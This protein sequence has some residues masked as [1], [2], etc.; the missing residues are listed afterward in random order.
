ML[1]EYEFKIRFS[2]GATQSVFAQPGFGQAEKINS[3]W[4]FHLGDTDQA[5]AKNQLDRSWRAVQLP[6]DWGVKQPLSPTLASAT[7]YLPGGIGWYRKTINIPQEDKGQKLYIY[8]EGVYNRSEVFVN[9]Q[10]VG[11]R[12]NGYISFNYDITPHIKYGEKNTI[13]FKVVG[14]NTGSR[15][16]GFLSYT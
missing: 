16:E 2:C 10:S 12:P 9:G 11:K 7:G 1:L 15:L 6:H 3:N 14:D 8:F 13:A 4:R 5:M